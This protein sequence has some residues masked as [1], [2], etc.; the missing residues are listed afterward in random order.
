M[1]A[2]IFL[3]L[4]GVVA[5]VVDRCD[6]QSRPVSH[7]HAYRQALTGMIREPWTDIH[8]PVESRQALRAGAQGRT[9]VEPARSSAGLAVQPT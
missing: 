3:I 4:I 8:V 7:D 2:V 1:D 5:L 9:I 6:D